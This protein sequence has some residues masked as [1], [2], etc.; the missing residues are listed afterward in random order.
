MKILLA[1]D[2]HDMSAALVAI[3]AHSGYDVDA[4]YDGKAA[5]EKAAENMYDC[6][7]FDVMMP[8]M[9]GIEALKKLRSMGN[10][11]PAIMLT[12]K[13]EVNDKV[14]GLDA[15]ADDYLTKPFAMGELLARI[16]SMT[17]R[18]DSY[19]PA[20]LSI[21]A[22]D[23]DIEEQELSCRNTIRLSSK[24]TKLMKFFMLN[25]GKILTTEDI[26]AHVWKGD[27]DVDKSIVWVY[28]SYLREK[29]HSIGAN[30]QITGC[31][32]HE[33]SLIEK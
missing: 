28:I 19:A 1:E 30:I 15:G 13:A 11:T 25:A 18:N 9:D 5:L 8:K 6:F 3:L 31:K 20:K 10:L 4:V 27:I 12:A 23:L 2:E 24:E 16:R 21:G 32:D 14:T 22:V 26:F 17:R 29:M 7:I 33:F